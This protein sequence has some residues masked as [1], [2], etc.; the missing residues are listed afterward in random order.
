MRSP[1]IADLK[2]GT[3]SFEVSAAPEKMRR[4]LSHI[5]NTTTASHAIR[6][7]DI[8]TR[9]N[10]RVIKHF[11]RRDGQRMSASNLQAALLAF[12]PGDRLAAFRSAIQSVKST[13]EQTQSIFPNMRLYSASV[14]VVYDG[15][16]EESAVNVRI[17]DF[18]HAYID[19]V[20]EGGDATDLSY[21]DNSVKGL[22]SL[23]KFAEVSESR[24]PFGSFPSCITSVVRTAL[25][26][27]SL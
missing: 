22:E 26:W 9:K 12:L 25:G 14:L 15:D 2:L 1:C 11:D 13:L 7:I 10:G 24:P 17:I 19:V 8:C 23:I 4:Q 3:R 16:S 5:A 21:D 18:A 6:C 27:T 20:A